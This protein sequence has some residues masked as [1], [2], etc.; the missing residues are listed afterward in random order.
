MTQPLI[1]VI[2]QR[3]EV[4]TGMVCDPDRTRL[5]RTLDE[6]VELYALLPEQLAPGQSAG[7]RVSGSREAPLPLRVDP[8]DLTMPA[9]TGRQ[10]WT[11][12]S[13][14]LGDQIGHLSVASILDS[15][16]RDWRGSIAA[17]G[18]PGTTV[19]ELAGWLRIWLEAACQDHPAIDEFGIEMFALAAALRRTCGLVEPLP[20]L[21]DAV[22]ARCDNLSLHRLPGEDRIECGV[23]GRRLTEDEYGQWTKMLVADLKEKMSA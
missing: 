12:V 15:W 13:D 7:E 21:L 5:A 1:C 23:C 8:L 11:A 22:C 14:K 3:R 10:L 18:N 4:R 6:I 19:V 9:P 17:S 16:V 2:C 20:A